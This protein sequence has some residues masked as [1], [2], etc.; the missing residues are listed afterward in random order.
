MTDDLDA[1]RARDRAAR[2]A[3]IYNNDSSKRERDRRVGPKP[4]SAADAR[5]V[6]HADERAAQ[7]RRHHGESE[8]IRL[9]YVE[10]RNK[11]LQT[12]EP[13]PANLRHDE[14]DEFKVLYQKHEREQQAMKDRHLRERAA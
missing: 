5:A 1:M 3:K 9:K 7:Q 14:A 10:K 13:L 2:I 6:R 11:L 4:G 12:S 8:A